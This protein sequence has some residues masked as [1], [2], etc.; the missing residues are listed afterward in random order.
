MI[1]FSKPSFIGRE[2]ELELLASFLEK[3]AASLLVIKGRRRIGKSR[4]I[5]EFAKDFSFYSLA[6]IAPTKKTTAQSERDEFASQLAKQGF[7]KIQATDWNDVFWLLAEKTKKGRVIILFDEIS[8]MGSKDPN[9][10]GKLKNGWDT[11]FSKNPKLMLVLCGSASSWIEKNIMSSTGFVGRISHTLTLDELPLRDCLKFW[12]KKEDRISLMEK[13][14]FLSV[15]GGVPRYL[16]ELN[17]RLS[18]EENI[19][20]L[21]FT[22]GALLVDEFD[23]IFGNVFLRRSDIY[24]KITE[25]LSSGSKEYTDIC[26][27]LSDEPAGRI[28]EYLEEL[29]LAGFVKRDYTWNLKSTQDAKLSRYR[30]SDNYLRFYLKYITKYKTK[31]DRNSFEFKSLSALPGWDTIMA[32]QFENLVLRN[33][34]LIW[35]KLKIRPED[36]V[37]ENPF[38]QRKTST[39][40]GCQIDYMIQTRYGS[41]YSCE[42]KFSKAPIPSKVIHEVQQKISKL[43]RPKGLS[44]RAV[45]IHLNGVHSDIPESDYFSD[46]IDFGNL[47]S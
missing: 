6:G 33:R 2:P 29:Q 1:S 35:N 26:K 13:L 41:L 43:K 38:F 37:S 9:F 8:W 16:E 18:A 10:L 14:K 30:L 39:Q 34:P 5:A 22:K 19:K 23:H 4:L 15:T 40:S 12:G 17:P 44:C 32:L 27:I 21:C 24:R 3:P 11:A 42:I 31:I 46:I 20:R 45:L 28:F 7:P 36:I 25:V 47:I